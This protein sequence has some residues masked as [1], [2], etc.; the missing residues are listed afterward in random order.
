[1]GNFKLIILEITEKEETLVREQYYLD[2]YEP[3]YNILTLADSSTGFKHTPDTIEKIR[4]KA[5]G[6]K[7]SIEVR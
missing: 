4:E 3:E 7:H 5:L 6:R 1:M 2:K